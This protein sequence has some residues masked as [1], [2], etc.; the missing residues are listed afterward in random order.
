MESL[1]D[2]II[3]WNN[4]ILDYLIEYKRQH[5]DFQFWVRTK[6][7]KG[8]LQ[9][10]QW[11]QGSDYIF[12]GFY[13]QGD[14]KNKTRTIGFVVTFDNS[15]PYCYLEV[16]FGSEENKAR[17]DF[18]RKLVEK[19]Q[20]T[21]KVSETKYRRYYDS[22][23]IQFNL[24][25]FLTDDKPIIDELIK[26]H[27]LENDFI[28]PE[29]KF[30]N[31]VDRV[32]S[33]RKYKNNVMYEGLVEYLTHNKNI[34][35]Y[36]PPGT[37]KTY[38]IRSKLYPYFTEESNQLTEEEYLQE[39]V[40]NYTWWQV[41]AAILMEKGNAKVPE[42]KKHPLLLAKQ[43][44]NEV[45]FLDQTLWGHL[46][47]HTIAECENVKTQN[48]IEPLIFDKDAKSN[49]TVKEELVQNSTPEV[50]EIL[51]KSKSY[52]PNPKKDERFNF[53]TF[54]QSTTYEDFIEGIKPTM[55]E[56]EGGE[57]KYKIEDGIFKKIANLADK[58][59]E[60][61]YAIFIDEIN[62]GNIA[63]IFGE[64]IT[65]IEPDKRKGMTN[66]I[67]ATLPYSKQ[68][69]LVPSNLY[70]IGTMNTADRS[71]EALDTALR[72]RFT[73]IEIPP[74]PELLGVIEEEGVNINLSKLLSVINERIEVLLDKD[75]QIGHAYFMEIDHK[76][77]P[78]S[79]LKEVFYNKIIP[80]MEEYFYGDLGKM[81]LVIGED[82]FD[83]EI[84][85]VNFAS[86]QYPYKHQLQQK[87]RYH[88]IPELEDDDFIL[89]LRKI[90]E[91][92]S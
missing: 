15:R 79:R 10:G 32:L 61:E 48:R 25:K 91:S 45:R 17:I 58:N 71:I 29:D 22:E 9:K 2:K 1:E 38:E 26:G 27:H 23:D 54:H 8:R 60:K 68:P 24:N 37:G 56:G 6:D 65:L 39:L 86:S 41:I 62:R 5:N 53:V 78:S 90:Y 52:Q 12:V 34:I 21:E 40:A 20:F 76:E 80:L 72:R 85:T 89:A 57:L 46:Q 82:F 13:N 64:L 75:H 81:E 88:L 73:F 63:N 50:A 77:R 66:E 14:S 16:V 92:E 84:T 49:W 69:F 35:F 42:I 19:L 3:H 59:P 74:K 11:F 44:N 43:R 18:Y 47:T 51:E 87:V 7:L 33:T 4:V 70:I 55:E 30:Q 83:H 31:S 67:K 28:I 36:G